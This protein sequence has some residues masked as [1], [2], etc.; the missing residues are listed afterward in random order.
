MFL[1]HRLVRANVQFIRSVAYINSAS[2]YAAS[3]RVLSPKV[4]HQPFDNLTHLLIRTFSVSSAAMTKIQVN[5]TMLLTSVNVYI[6][7]FFFFFLERSPS[8]YEFLISSDN[9]TRVSIV[10]LSHLVYILEKGFS[11][12]TI[13]TYN[14]FFFFFT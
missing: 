2:N 7:A 13:N 12:S 10:I 5:E 6:Y 1:P 9:I 3:T 14:N 8:L 4:S 11:F